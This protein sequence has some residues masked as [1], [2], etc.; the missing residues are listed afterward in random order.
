MGTDER[1]RGA[2]RSEDVDELDRMARSDADV[3]A[4][5]VEKRDDGSVKEPEDSEP[6]V[7]AHYRPKA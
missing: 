3:E 5:S 1:D 4:H 2:K 7:E 6:D